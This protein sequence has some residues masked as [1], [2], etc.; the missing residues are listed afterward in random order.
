MSEV[1]K[2]EGVIL[3]PGKEAFLQG[4][5]RRK[6]TMLSPRIPP[7]ALEMEAAVLGALMLEKN[8]L[9]KIVDI[10][11]PEMFYSDAN[12]IIFDAVGELFNSSMPVDILTIKNHLSKTGKLA[13]VGG[14]YY[15]TELTSM[16]A[17]AANIEYH[18]RIIAE[19]YLMREL[20]IIGDKVVNEAYDETQ[21][22][23]NLLDST[24]KSLFQLSE[25]NLRRNY[26]RMS[27]LV[28]STLRRLE[29]IKGRGDGIIGVASGFSGLDHY[30]SGFQ[31]SDL[32][33]CAARPSMGKT[34]FTLTIARNAAVR[35]KVP[36]AFFSLE[37]AAT[38]LVQRL[39][40]AE[41][42]LDAKKVRTGDLLPFEWEQLN[43]R[44][45]ELSNAELYIDDTPALSIMELR[46]KARRL[47]AEKNI[48][49]IIVDYLQLMTAGNQA[50]NGN[51]EQ[52][53]AAISRSLKELAKELDVPVVALSQLSRAVETRGGD[54]KPQLSDLRESGSIEQDADVVMF[55]YRPEYYDLKVYED[56][57]STQGIC[58]VIIAKQRNGP[59]G[60]LKL[61]FINKFAKFVDLADY[62]AN[63]YQQGG[64]H[65][66]GESGAIVRPSRFND[67][68]NDDGGEYSD[69]FKP[70]F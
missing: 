20:I 14:A 32:I 11:R 55:L 1:F 66:Q 6:G 65:E 5:D 54:K 10:L 53:I 9:N 30:T 7:S 28:V 49:M 42:E 8:A 16:V 41:A 63:P 46:A 22:V 68:P 21:D 13:S 31:N 37:M 19:K 52:Q 2:P 67:D 23:F 18:S 12:R 39:L 58:E 59:V 24:E 26:K 38:Q 45:G 47:K 64:G 62:G 48:G 35:F 29:E 44:I 3:S 69:S 4:K 40:C 34:A 33:I 15:L 51:R 57:S 61:Q 60:D 70:P 50:M 36:V 43:T 27:D 17:S 56:G 25:T